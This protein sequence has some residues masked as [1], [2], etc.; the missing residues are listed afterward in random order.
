MTVPRAITLAALAVLLA[1]TGTPS[2]S[3]S[4]TPKKA[5]FESP[6]GFGTTPPGM[7]YVEGGEFKMGMPIRVFDG[8]KVLRKDDEGG[9]EFAAYEV[10]ERKVKL[11]AFWMDR[12]EVTNAQYLTFLEDAHKGSFKVEGNLNTLVAIATQLYGE[13]S[14]DWWLAIY[15]ANWNKINPEK[16]N[17]ALPDE[18]PGGIPAPQWAAEELK[19]GLVLAI[20]DLPIPAN[21]RDHGTVPPGIENHPVCCVTW[22]HANMYAAW[23]GKHLPRGIEWERAARGPKNNV[24]TWG[25]TW[26]KDD[27]K[28]NEDRLNW[29]LLNPKHPARSK[30]LSVLTTPVGSFPDGMSGYG[31]FDMLGNVWEWTDEALRA[32]PGSKLEAEDWWDVAKVIRGG[33]YGNTKT[34][35]R[36]TFRTGGNG[37]DLI[38]RARDAMQAVGFRCARWNVP[39]ADRAYMMWHALESDVK[40]PKEKA[41]PITFNLFGGV[42]AEAVKYDKQDAGGKKVFVAGRCRSITILPREQVDAG[43]LKALKALAKKARGG[44]GITVGLFHT[45]L[46]IQISRPVAGTTEK[47]DKKAKK[48]ADAHVIPEE[49]ATAEPGDYVLNLHDDRLLLLKPKLMGLEVV[50]YLTTRKK[51]EE[52][53][54]LVILDKVATGSSEV[55]M[56]LDEVRIAFPV[57]TRAQGPKTF[58]IQANIKTAQ[59]RIFTMDWMSTKSK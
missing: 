21:W 15:H 36:T 1:A 26:S 18:F 38:F 14:S 20:Y 51:Q 17:A 49:D 28:K 13:P 27:W 50:G 39:G 56:G 8:A 7:A 25:G 10:P 57:G 54:D 30:D 43:L 47:K 12:Y 23:A 6:K 41:R 29:A 44:N 37:R 42:G 34:M 4:A 45:D 2:V 32:Y 58:V 55:D 53:G 40:L 5:P 52:L 9:R 59:K 22:H 46:E 33:G 48:K 19:E 35:L 31:M 16:K 3:Q 11:A 24:R